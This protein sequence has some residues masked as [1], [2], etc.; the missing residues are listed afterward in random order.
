[1]VPDGSNA[2][3]RPLCYKKLHLQGGLLSHKEGP[4]RNPSDVINVRLVTIVRV[5]VA[6][7]RN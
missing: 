1:M 2:M 5:N 3:G 6:G 4:K 7:G